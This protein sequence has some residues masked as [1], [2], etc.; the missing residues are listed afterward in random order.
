MKWPLGNTGVGSQFRDIY[1]FLG[2]NRGENN[3]INILELIHSSNNL[4]ESLAIDVGHYKINK[5]DFGRI[6]LQDIHRRKPVFGGYDLIAFL[7]KPIFQEF[8]HKPVV[9]H[10]QYLLHNTSLPRL[11]GNVI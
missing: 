4:A 11:K 7:C 3:D 8:P 10:H 1:L 2:S 9:I 5:N 6:C